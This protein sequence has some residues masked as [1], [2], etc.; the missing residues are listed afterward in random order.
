MIANQRAADHRSHRQR[1]A[2]DRR[3]YAE[4][5]GALPLIGVD[6][7]DHR[8]RA[9]LAGRCAEAH[10]RAPGDEDADVRRGSR[11][12]GPGAEDGNPDQHHALA[13]ELIADHAEAEHRA[14][15]GQRI[16]AH[17]PL[18]RRDARVQLA[19]DVAKRDANDRVVEECQEEDDAQYG[20]GEGA[21]AAQGSRRLA[22]GYI[23]RADHW[24]GG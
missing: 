7:P 8:Q 16:R 2:R 20:Q 22:R 13:A 10:D 19:L 5:P 4:R 6:M 14:S 9:R 12:D 17:H 3:P 18:Q 15:E 23:G 21:T 11:H 1:D 24:L